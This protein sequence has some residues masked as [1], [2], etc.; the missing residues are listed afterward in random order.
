[1]PEKLS[2]EYVQ[3]FQVQDYWLAVTRVLSSVFLAD[4]SMVSS[5]NNEPGI[6]DP[7]FTGKIFGSRVKEIWQLTDLRST[8]ACFQ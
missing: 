3:G 8:A 1:M 6:V 7:K 4:T 2:R 5:E